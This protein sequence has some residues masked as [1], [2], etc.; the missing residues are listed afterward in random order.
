M[1]LEPD[2]ATLKEFLTDKKAL[3]IG[4]IECYY[5]VKN[6]FIEPETWILDHASVIRDIPLRIV[7]GRFDV[8]CPPQSAWELHQ[9]VPKSELVIVQLG[10]H[11]PL[12]PGMT[13]ELIRATEEFKTAAKW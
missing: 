8:I 3:S 9:A 13:D 6:F 10:S 11:S 1:N 7:Q 4:R 5:T 2:P 12:D